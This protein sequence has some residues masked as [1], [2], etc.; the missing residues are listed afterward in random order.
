MGHGDGTTHWWYR[1][2]RDGRMRPWLDLLLLL[3][4]VMHLEGSKDEEE[5]LEHQAGE[6]HE[7][8]SGQGLGQPLVVADQPAEA[9][10]PGEAA[11]HDPAAGP[12]HQTPPWP[13]VLD[14]PPP[15]AAWLRR[16]R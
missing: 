15:D 5:A 3:E 11:F 8:E 2:E 12:P 7:V 13:R 1:Q 9:R 14:H 10:R 16:L 4:A 6:G